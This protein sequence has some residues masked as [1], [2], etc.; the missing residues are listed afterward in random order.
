MTRRQCEIMR[1]VHG[2]AQKNAADYYVD[3]PHA[4]RY[5]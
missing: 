3:Q 1:M 4:G 2:P 5:D